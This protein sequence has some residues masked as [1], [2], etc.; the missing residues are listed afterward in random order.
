MIQSVLSIMTPWFFYMKIPAI[1]LENDFIP[2]CECCVFSFLV[3][4]V[5]DQVT[6]E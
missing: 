1:L 4:L 6:L 3:M 5:P 2:P